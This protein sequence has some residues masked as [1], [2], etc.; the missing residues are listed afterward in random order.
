MPFLPEALYA[1]AQTREADRRAATDHGLG[2]GLLMERAG[3]AAFNAL[4][5]RFPRARRVAMI[6]GP[7]NNGGDGYVVARL[8]AQAGLTAT[9]LSPDA[10]SR[11]RGDAAAAASAWHAAGGRVLPFTVETMRASDVVVDAIF[12]TGLE[13]PVEGEWRN[14]IDAINAAGQPVLALDVPSGL[15]ADSGRVLGGAV[16]AAATIT[17][18]GLKAGLFTA[19][20]REHCGSILFDDLGVPAEV[21]SGLP[22]QARRITTA[23]LPRL[24]PRAL[25]VHK[26][27]AGRVV[28][29]GGAPGMPGAVRLAGEAAYRAGAGLVTVAT[30]PDHAPLVSATRPELIGIGV[31]DSAS[32]TGLLE[33]AQAA[34]IGPGLGQGPWAQALW[35]QISDAA[36]PLVVDAEALRLLARA[37]RSRPDWVLTPHPGEAAALLGCRVAD[38]E[39]DRFA[40]VRRLR[41]SYGGVC[42]LKGS[43]TL[44]AG[45]RTGP[46]LCD[47][48]TPALASGG[49]GDVL[50]GMI[51]ALLAQGLV[52]IEAARLAVWAHAVAGERAAAGIDRGLMAS[53]LFASLPSVIN[54]QVVDENRAPRGR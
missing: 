41:E 39:S 12:G 45:D 47:R 46:W 20:G 18:I 42:V 11:R 37:P 52:P 21:F 22:V 24:M 25:H 33:R 50:S 51:A 19:H 5:E 26:G 16:R 32:L 27:D 8:A 49:T 34:A 31:T 4:R 36:V 14:V 35:Q 6:C 15:H 17:F 2:G 7:G 38:V 29:V 3:T 30:H 54:S 23:S 44:I 48:G 9:V 40:A 1:A 53:D 28:I 13:R 10:G 43:G